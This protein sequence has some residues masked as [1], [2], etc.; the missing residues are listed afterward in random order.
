[1]KITVVLDN[2]WPIVRRK[3]RACMYVFAKLF[4]W[5]ESFHAVQVVPPRPGGTR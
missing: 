2:P 5:G 3:S 4:L 1:M